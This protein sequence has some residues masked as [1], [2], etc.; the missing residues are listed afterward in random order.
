[1]NETK[2]AERAGPVGERVRWQPGGAKDER[3]PL[4]V[5]DHLEPDRVAFPLLPPGRALQE[6]GFLGFGVR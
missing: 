4:R 5:V 2:D 6:R 1:M 3:L